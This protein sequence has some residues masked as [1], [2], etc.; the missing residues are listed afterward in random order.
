MR[1]SG[2][3]LSKFCLGWDSNW[4]C[5]KEEAYQ[6]VPESTLLLEPLI[7]NQWLND[8]EHLCNENKTD[9]NLGWYSELLSRTNL[10]LRKQEQ[11]N[12]TDLT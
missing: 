3:I 2:W 9:S 11:K 1:L 8:D 12:C 6:L 7:L 5:L 4:C 10:K